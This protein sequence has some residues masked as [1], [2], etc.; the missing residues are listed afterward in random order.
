MPLADPPLLLA[1]ASVVAGRSQ[2][3]HP[4]DV[5]VDAGEA[6]AVM[7]AN[8]SGKSTLIRAALG[9]IPLSQGNARL[10][11][12]NAHQ[13]RPRVPWHRVGY[14]PQR[15]AINSPV[16]S[17]AFEVAQ[18]GLLG[19]RKWRVS[20]SQRHRVMAAMEQMDVANLANRPFGVLSGGQAQRVIIARALV[21]N[22][23]LLLLDEPLAG[24]DVLT[25]MALARLL[26]DLHGQGRTVVMVLHELGPFAE[27]LDRALT[28]ANG[29]IVRDG[30]LPRDHDHGPFAP[31]EHLHADHKEPP[32][33]TTQRSLP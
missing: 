25:Q 28:L 24:V 15:A 11:G 26:A 20:R 27:I 7:G 12:V 3:L 10:F 29:Q 31:H 17:T 19:A 23:D 21:R 16:P 32:P 22:P 13:G 1:G 14:V 9:L 33:S 30:P 6:V 18:T 4:T 8:G 5:R 2:I